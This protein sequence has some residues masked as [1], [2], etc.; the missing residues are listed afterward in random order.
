V[1]SDVDPSPANNLAMGSTGRVPPPRID[2]EDVSAIPGD[3]LV[4]RIDEI[5]AELA[6]LQA[7]YRQTLAEAA[8]WRTQLAGDPTAAGVFARARP[9]KRDLIPSNRAC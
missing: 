9:D 2:L 4:R 3:D 5:A 7:R 8:G 1:A 6:V